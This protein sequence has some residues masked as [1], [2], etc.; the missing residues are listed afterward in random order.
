[1]TL[2]TG[3][4]PPRFPRWLDLFKGS[5][6]SLTVSQAQYIIGL[7]T[8]GTGIE[9]GNEFMTQPQAKAPD[10]IVHVALG[11]QAGPEAGNPREAQ[12]LGVGGSFFWFDR[13]VWPAARP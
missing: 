9:P 7:P 2:P 6:F 11:A 10:R 1:M 12:A 13:T 3:N 4:E 5:L 8:A